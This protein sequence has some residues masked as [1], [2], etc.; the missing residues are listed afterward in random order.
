M[1]LKTNILDLLGTFCALH[2]IDVFLNTLDTP[3]FRGDSAIPCVYYSVILFRVFPSVL[4]LVRLYTHSLKDNF[5]VRQ[6]K[7]LYILLPGCSNTDSFVFLSPLNYNEKLS[8]VFQSTNC[9]FVNVALTS[10]DMSC[11][12]GVLSNITVSCF[13]FCPFLHR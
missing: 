7:H 4:I 9:R 1:L 6:V 13:S 12:T 8:L 10:K 5:Q 3:L 11:C 2:L